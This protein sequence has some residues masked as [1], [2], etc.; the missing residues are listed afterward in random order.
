MNAY[1]TFM[2][3]AKRL[4]NSKVA[5]DHHHSSVLQGVKHFEDGRLAVT[6]SHRLYFF[7]AGHDKGD[8]LITPDGREIK[9]VN[10]PEVTRLIPD[11]DPK[12]EIYHDVKDLMVGADCVVTLAKAEGVV[13]EMSYKGNILSALLPESSF[14]HE[15]SKAY[16]DGEL[17]SNASY[18]LD[19][20]K[21]F[22]ALDY[23][24][25]CLKV[26]GNL[27]PFILESLDRKLLVV[28]LPIR[29]R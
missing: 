22:R 16:E 29:R 12:Q 13:P 26:H 28:L 17:L 27:R 21:L 9:K 3:H 2:K 1:E 14:T 15:L 20:L 4:T 7:N 8:K 18:W 11:S 6:D 5:K 19:A 25:V 10:Y 23:D 24:K